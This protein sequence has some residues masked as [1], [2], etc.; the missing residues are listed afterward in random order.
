MGTLPKATAAV[1]GDA[2]MP[3]KLEE[4]MASKIVE[5]E[6]EAEAEGVVWTSRACT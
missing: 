1:V 5:A 3:S 4:A 2:T 6:A